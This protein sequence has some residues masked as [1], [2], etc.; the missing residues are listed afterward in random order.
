[1]LWGKGRPLAAQN[2][3]AGGD[4]HALRAGVLAAV[5]FLCP[6]FSLP[7][8]AK[9]PGAK[10][11]FSGWCHR[12]GTLRQTESLVG[13]R[14]YLL[15]SYYDDCSRDR[16]N[17]CGLTSSGTVFRPDL[18]D[19]AASPLFPDGTVI[20][21]YNPRS[22]GASILRITN[23]GPY[24]GQR[25][26]DVSR[27]AA[28]SLG[29]RDEGVAHLVVSVLKAPTAKEATYAWR[30]VYPRVPGYLGRFGNFDLAYAAGL[31]KLDLDEPR[32]TDAELF[33]PDTPSPGEDQSGEE[34]VLK[35]RPAVS[36]Y[37]AREL[38][39][40]K[41]LPRPVRRAPPMG[42]DPEAQTADAGVPPLT[43]ID[44][45]FGLRKFIGA[46]RLAATGTK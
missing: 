22:G 13:W 35:P 40:L 18:P 24:S 16:L 30:R 37:L 29:F 31:Q 1:M 6:H 5:L 12:V 17:P 14:G 33:A 2:S 7:A 32:A 9:T 41:I 3:F 46:P 39:M 19:N 25:K 11:C 42:A 21:A 34:L 36:P 20:L 27:A 43:A 23:A 44:F 8:V 45:G 26:L 4:H 28:E 15:A 10:Y 38:V